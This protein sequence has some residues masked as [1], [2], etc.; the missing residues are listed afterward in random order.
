MSV[1]VLCLGD[2]HM[3]RRASRVSGTYRS[4]DAW[5]RA[6]DIAIAERVDLV[7][8]SGDIVDEESKSYEALGPLE[9]G[10]RRLD[11]AGIDTV[12]VSGNHDW[13]VL[14]RLIGASGGER[15]HL[16]GRYG[17]WERFTLRRDNVPVLFVD[18]WSFPRGRVPES[19]LAHYRPQGGD[20]VPLLGLFHTDLDAMVSNH[21]PVRSVDLWRYP[22][23]FWLLGHIHAARVL[24]GPQGRGT[25]IYPGSPYALDPGEPGTH[26]V[27]L[28]T[29]QP[30]EPV[31]L[32]PI[33]L[34]PVRYESREVD[35]ADV[36]DEEGFLR[37]LSSAMRDPTFS[38]QSDGSLEAI[39]LRLTF[40]GRSAAHQDILA[41]SDRA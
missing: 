3:G 30:G 33:P 22:V 19:P 32:R 1:R 20:G 37:A 18:G 5:S 4:V 25:A 12:A 2:V 23:D 7:A 17:A 8:L 13:D 11:G 34:S 41:W 38:S 9:A 10:I 36:V 28:A 35:L 39:S 31:A 16:L 24:T 29:F 40:T 14:P 15:F 21:A 27:W 6:V 26:G